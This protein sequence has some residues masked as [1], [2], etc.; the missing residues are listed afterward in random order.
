MNSLAKMVFKS[1]RPISRPYDDPTVI[2]LIIVKY[3]I[4]KPLV[5]TRSSITFYS[6]FIKLGMKHNDISPIL[7]PITY[8]QETI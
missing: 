8:S 5:D 3:G 2:K 1:A 6:S 7:Y 4:S